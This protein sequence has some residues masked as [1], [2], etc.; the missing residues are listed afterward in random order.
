MSAADRL[1][2]RLE[3]NISQSLGVRTAA[4]EA[5]DVG[6]DEPTRAR[7][8]AGPSV[9]RSRARALGLMDIRNI[10]PDPEQPRKDFDE[11]ALRHLSESLK[12]FGQLLPIR[13]RWEERLG[14]WMIISGERRYRAALAAG[15]E[16]VTCHFVEEDLS[17]SQILEEQVVENCLR[18]DLRPVEQARAYRA[19]MEAN[20][21][22]ARRVAEE[23]HLASSTVVKA[24]AL[25]Q[26]PEGIQEQV[27]AGTIPASAAYELSR[28]GPAD[29]ES[30]AGQITTE[31]L[32]RDR[33]VALVRKTAGRK[34]VRSRREW[35]EATDTA[36]PPTLAADRSS[37]VTD[38]Y[39]YETDDHSV[40]VYTFSGGVRLT[41]AT[42]R[43]ATGVQVAASL[44]SALEDFRKRLGKTLD[45]VAPWS[46]DPVLR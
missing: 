11:E 5:A 32:T 25:L 30:L 12:K 22:S 44:A 27:D 41:I 31:G 33:A 24:L 36:T 14:K 40:L 37:S 20:A 26:L 1:L 43:H 9:G 46:N 19:L 18:E 38:R 21:W 23:L 28:L 8:A 10:T 17:S 15:M 13:V 6:H 35:R 7:D 4:G 34:P 29:Q 16:S 3:G 39:S 2:K 42:P 45:R